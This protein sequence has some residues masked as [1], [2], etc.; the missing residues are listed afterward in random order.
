MRLALSSH[1]NDAPEK[2]SRP[3]DA[4]RDG[5]VLSGGAGIVVLEALDTARQR[6]AQVYAEMIGHGANSDGH[7][8]ILPEPE[9]QQGAACMRSA[10][11]SA[12][13]T[14]GDIDYINTHG[15]STLDGDVAEVNAMREVFGD[16]M[17]AFSST[18]SMSG[19]AI[20][21][22]GAHELIY[23]VGMLQ[24][25]FIAPSINIDRLDPAFDGL[26][27]V[28]ETRSAPLNIVLSNSFGF[29]GHERDVDLK[30]SRRM[31]R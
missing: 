11:A 15:T 31:I 17:P 27:I 6:G 24:Q 12:G 26:P 9:G 4:D 30:K 19:H 18:K 3:Y 14:A 28:T 21:A 29:G 22:A 5:F 20:G 13:I 23:C 16:H 8:F 2:A 10:I 25:Q 7:D 1:F